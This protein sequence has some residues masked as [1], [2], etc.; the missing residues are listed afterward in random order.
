MNFG[1][2][3]LQKMLSF[4]SISEEPRC[5]VLSEAIEGIIHGM[6]CFLEARQLPLNSSL[7]LRPDHWTFCNVQSRAVS[8]SRP[9][10][11]LVDL[12]G[13]AARSRSS[14]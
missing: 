11:K 9:P 5:C 10:A 1:D 7:S 6:L 4:L 14:H 13:P 3:Q 2:A 12:S 8:E